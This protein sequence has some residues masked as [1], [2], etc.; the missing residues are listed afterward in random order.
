MTDK[1]E[2]WAVLDMDGRALHSVHIFKEDAEKAAWGLG[3][4]VR[5]ILDKKEY[6]LEEIGFMSKTADCL[7]INFDDDLSWRDGEKIYRV[8]RT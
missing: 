5:M 4:V 2:A 7:D 3:S 6:D 1:I 8:K